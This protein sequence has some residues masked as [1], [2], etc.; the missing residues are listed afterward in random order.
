VGALPYT[1]GTKHPI[2]DLSRSHFTFVQFMLT[3][4]M[5]V[6]MPSSHSSGH[7]P[8]QSIPK[9]SP[10]RWCHRT[11]PER[12]QKIVRTTMLIVAYFSQRSDGIAVELAK[13]ELARAPSSNETKRNN[14]TSEDHVTDHMHAASSL[15]LL[16]LEMWHAILGSYRAYEV[17]LR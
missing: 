15:P 8:W 17:A 2:S 4:G 5:H 16:P 7:H 6:L 13:S 3:C 9:W 11:S 12:T 14:S 1:E 10:T